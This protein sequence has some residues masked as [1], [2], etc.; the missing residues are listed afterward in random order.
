MVADVKTS[1]FLLSATVRVARIGTGN[2]GQV[3]SA[4]L[5]HPA[6]YDAQ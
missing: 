3:S 6:C 4:S 1:L 2:T 5:V